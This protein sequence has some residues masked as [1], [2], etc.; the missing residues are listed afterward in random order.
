M[1][2]NPKIK[3]FKKCASDDIKIARVPFREP[4]QPATGIPNKYLNDARR[5]RLEMIRVKEM[6]KA[7]RTRL[8]HILIQ[9]LKAKYG[10]SHIVTINTIVDE[11]L[12]SKDD[13][14][15]EDWTTLEAKVSEVIRTKRPVPP[16]KVAPE[17]PKPMS[18]TESTGN[19][20][21][22]NRPNVPPGCE[23]KTL[24]KYQQ[25]IDE[26]KDNLKAQNQIKKRLQ[27]RAAL[28]HQLQ[29]AKDLASVERNQDK[30]YA[31]FVSEDVREFR[32]EEDFKKILKKEK[33]DWELNKIKGEIKDRRL[34]KAAD[35]EDAQSTEKKLI[36]KSRADLAKEQAAI[37]VIR[38]QEREKLNQMLQE[39][40]DNE[41]RKVANRKKDMEESVVLIKE[42]ELKLD[43][44]AVE[45]ESAFKKRMEVMDLNALKFEE[46]EAGA[47]QKEKK[48][49]DEQFALIEKKRKEYQILL[50]QQKS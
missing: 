28:D 18:N 48:L 32:K 26:E 17:L 21:A 45:R 42:Q 27:F 24:N 43:R 50:L 5:K 9:K 39:C 2:K 49:R 30:I 12:S 34:K 37:Q 35:R 15:P 33:N 4:T 11:F 44:E 47:L 29:M 13:L 31:E 19:I 36:E 1:P 23:W 38:L 16:E 25:L 20:W 22:D 8:C 10:I 7:K 14:S 46:S 41:N 6:L 40:K 3:F